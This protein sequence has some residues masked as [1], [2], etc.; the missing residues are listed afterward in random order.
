MAFEHGN[1]LSTGRPKGAGNKTTSEIRQMLSDFVSDNWGIVQ[2][3]YKRLPV[4]EQVSILVKILPF[5]IP[6][7][8]PIEAPP[9][10]PTISRQEV[11]KEFLSRFSNEELIGLIDE[12]RSND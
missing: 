10:A 6:K 11:I 9:E 1:K 12:L 5:I 8:T 3:N 4:D 7:L 2:D